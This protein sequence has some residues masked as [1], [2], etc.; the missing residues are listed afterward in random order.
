MEGLLILLFVFLKEKEMHGALLAAS[1]RDL[2][3]FSRSMPHHHQTSDSPHPFW[4]L[5]SPQ[6]SPSLF[7]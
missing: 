7:F 3:G 1:D 2:T 5:V 4:L 6:L